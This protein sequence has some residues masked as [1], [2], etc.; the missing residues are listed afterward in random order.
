[1]KNNHNE[2]LKY[3]SRDLFSN[4]TAGYRTKLLTVALVIICY[5]KMDIYP[6]SIL[7]IKIPKDSI[8]HIPS[9][10]SLV[11]IYYSYAWGV[12]AY[13][14][15]FVSMLDKPNACEG[16]DYSKGQ[17]GVVI[18][19]MY[20]LNYVVNIILPTLAFFYALYLVPGHSMSIFH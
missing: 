19:I 14:E 9:I 16:K 18:L 13:R 10:L 7:G 6:E 15:L 12:S 17:I 11:L 20:Y 8:E 5:V 1:M 4:E 2:L 3:Y